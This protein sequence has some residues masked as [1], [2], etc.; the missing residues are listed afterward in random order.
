MFQKVKSTC[1]Q[2]KIKGL[3]SISS[4][5]RGRSRLVDLVN[6]RERERRTCFLMILFFL[7][8]YT[9]LSHLAHFST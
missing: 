6:E 8:L 3:Q 1:K 7:K 9:D 4:C 2:L 5:L